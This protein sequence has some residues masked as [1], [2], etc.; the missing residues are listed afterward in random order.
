MNLIDALALG[1]VLKWDDIMWLK[2]TDVFTKLLLNKERTL[3]ERQMYRNLK[4]E[5]ANHRR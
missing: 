5:Q 2:Y 3:F 4:A 1:N